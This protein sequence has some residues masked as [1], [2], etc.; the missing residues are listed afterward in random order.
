MD[1][2]VSI[3]MGA[4]ASLVVAGMLLRLDLL[5]SR[6]KV[7]MGSRQRI[8]RRLRELHGTG[9]SDTG[10]P[11]AR[12]RESEA[13]SGSTGLRRRLWRDTSV[14]LVM[15]STG[16]MV[17]LAVTGSPVPAGD[18]LQA[19]A[20]A[21]PGAV[22]QASGNPPLSPTPRPI[23]AA[24]APPEPAATR[25]R[26]MAGP[27]VSDDRMAVL[28]ACPGKVDCFIYVVRRG[29][30]LTSI[31]NWFGIPYPEVLALNGHIRDPRTI[32]AGEQIR[33]PPPR[34]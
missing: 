10:G 27:S 1:L 3:L 19:T 15:V 7:D 17:V 32:H 21:K 8:A 22:T 33:L 26:S 11:A 25:T 30:N 23:A 2:R 4:L 20:T 6:A 9:E 16:S 31:A 13:P 14:A 18:V 12:A 28:T 34:R 5:R 29:D 24:T